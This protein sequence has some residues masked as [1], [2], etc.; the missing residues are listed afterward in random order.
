MKL[1]S[2]LQQWIDSPLYQQVKRQQA[3]YDRLF[4]K[5]LQEHAQKMNTLLATFP[6]EQIQRWQEKLSHSQNIEDFAVFE[7]PAFVEVEQRVEQGI[8][9]DVE[10]EIAEVG[11]WAKATKMAK[12][13][14]KIALIAVN[15]ITSIFELLEHIQKYLG[16]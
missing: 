9:T 1:D 4:P 13:G 2:R 12:N 10:K 6:I 5:E 11:R 8:A 15:G 16:D 3:Q 7:S 14:I